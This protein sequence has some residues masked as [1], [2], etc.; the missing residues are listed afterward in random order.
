M[1][2]TGVALAWGV[3]LAGW[4]GEVSPAWSQVP[5]VAP[6]QRRGTRPSTATSP[7]SSENEHRSSSMKRSR[8]PWRRE[9]RGRCCFA[10]AAAG[11]SWTT[12]AGSLLR[13]ERMPFPFGPKRRTW[14]L[15]LP[16]LARIQSESG[17]A[18]CPVQFGITRQV[19]NY[20]EL[21]VQVGEPTRPSRRHA[22]GWSPGG[23][24][25]TQSFRG[26]SGFVRGQRLRDAGD[27]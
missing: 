6:A 15:I 11:G 12:T 27:S 16:P 1:R 18:S 22:S 2:R 23:S 21:S 25:R 10:Q 17:V 9:L 5:A 13:I 7:G 14:S 20:G 3:L 8:T 24:G 19:R 4:L 26:S